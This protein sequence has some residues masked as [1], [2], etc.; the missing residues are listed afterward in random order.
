MIKNFF[1][2]KRQLSELYR[3]HDVYMTPLPG[4]KFNDFIR[5]S[6]KAGKRK[7]SI[8]VWVRIIDDYYRTF[9]NTTTEKRF[10]GTELLINNE[11][12]SV[13]LCRHYRI[14]LGL[15]EGSLENVQLEISRSRNPLKKIRALYNA[16]DSIIRTTT[17]ISVISL[18]LGIIALVL[19]VLSII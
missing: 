11:E 7:K 18:L 17:V 13:V 15:D 2:I 19:G 12:S 6:Y 8:Y 9:Y 1:C 10:G 16:P 3:D 4:I 5:I 14:R